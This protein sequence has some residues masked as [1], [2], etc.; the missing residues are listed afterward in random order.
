M[1]LPLVRAAVDAEHAPGTAAGDARLPHARRPLDRNVL[2]RPQLGNLDLLAAVA[3]V[4]LVIALT[5]AVAPAATV[6]LVVAAVLAA[7]VL[8]AAALALAVTVALVVA[9]AVALVAAARA[10]AGP[11]GV[12][13][14]VELPAPVEVRARRRS[15]LAG[16]RS[17]RPGRHLTG[18]SGECERRNHH[19]ERFSLLDSH[20]KVLPCAGWDVRHFKAR[21]G[22]RP[23]LSSSVMCVLTNFMARSANSR[24]TLFSVFARTCAMTLNTLPCAAR[25]RCTQILS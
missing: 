25:S 7:I 11:A 22:T 2:V 6:T 16:L 8:A 10:A 4:A 21:L 20:G 1:L 24:I 23:V 9:L 5:V 18:R 17:R 14:V 19:G 3:A 12:L 13:D 15:G